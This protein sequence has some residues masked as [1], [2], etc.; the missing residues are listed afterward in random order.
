MVLYILLGL[1]VDHS[2]ALEETVTEAVMILLIETCAM[3][4]LCGCL[5]SVEARGGSE[6]KQAR[7]NDI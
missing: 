6:S 1:E 7:L 5:P 3:Q 2:I 4:W